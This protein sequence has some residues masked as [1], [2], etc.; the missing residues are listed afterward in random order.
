MG[1]PTLDKLDQFGKTTAAALAQMEK[2]TF[3]ATLSS[4]Y[5]QQANTL[6]RQLPRSPVYA[7]VRAELKKQTVSLTDLHEACVGFILMG[8]D[9]RDAIKAAKS[10]LIATLKPLLKDLAEKPMAGL[11]SEQIAA[12]HVDRKM[13][14][15]A[16]GD[17]KQAE[18]VQSYYERTAKLPTSY[19]QNGGVLLVRN[20]V[21][22]LGVFGPALERIRALG[23]NVREFVEGYSVFDSQL[24]L[25]FDLNVLAKEHGV[26][27]G[28]DKKAQQAQRNFAQDVLNQYNS[29][30][31]RKYSMVNDVPQMFNG[32]AYFWLLPDRQ[33]TILRTRFPQLKE[34]WGFPTKI[35]RVSDKVDTR[36]VTDD[37]LEHIFNMAFKGRDVKFMAEKLNLEPSIIA[38]ILNGSELTHKTVDKRRELR[39]LQQRYHAQF[40][41]QKKSIEKE[42]LDNA[43]RDKRLKKPLTPEQQELLRQ[44]WRSTPSKL[45]RDLP[46]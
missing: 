34:S 41:D 6:L 4:E 27:R 18:L 19:T 31:A 24:L 26:K 1:M 37:K 45:F 40:V 25:G 9:A 22:V 43:Y 32:L 28:G 17:D 20:P 11:D 8:E 29:R 38:A 44:Q 2:N 21:V 13:G 5:L 23:V 16:E 42:A 15:V 14:N 12:A 3:D 30:H 33:L 46:D 10:E 39:D 36:K 7:D 35:S